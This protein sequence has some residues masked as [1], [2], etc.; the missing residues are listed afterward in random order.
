MKKILFPL[1]VVF[2][3]CFSVSAQEYDYCAGAGG[4]ADPC[5][6]R[7][8]AA[9]YYNVDHT[10]GDTT[11]CISGGTTTVTLTN[12][13]A[14]TDQNHTPGGTKSVL[15]EAGAKEYISVAISGLNYFNSAEGMV[16]VWYYVAE[17][18]GTNYL[19][20]IYIDASNKLITNVNASR[21]VSLNHVG[22][23]SDVAKTSTSTITDGQWN[24]I[25]IRW[26][27]DNNQIAIRINGGSWEV[28]T[29]GDAV[30]AFAAEP[31]SVQIGSTAVNVVDTYYTDDISL[32]TSAGV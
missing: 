22:Q 12:A 10:S 29:D 32:Y 11:A 31:S 1:L 7:G 28:D 6:N 3:L 23:A 5:A 24:Q 20:R 15:H 9:L 18:T 16:T 25:D 21:T 8:T 26:S 4:A 30:T 14:S 27:H 2:L 13:A 19:F 17:T